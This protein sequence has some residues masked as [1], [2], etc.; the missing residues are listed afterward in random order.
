MSMRVWAAT[1]CAL[2][3]SFVC[4]VAR[5]GT[6]TVWH[7]YRGAEEQALAQVSAR[8]EAAHPATH[9]ELLGIPYEAYA[10]K[11]EAAVPR[12]NGPDLFI[13][14]HQ[15][16]GPYAEE[17][18]ALPAGEAFPEDDVA[19]F[20]AVSV[21]AVTSGGVRWAVPL[22]NKCL[23]LYVND[24]LLRSTPL[25]LEGIAAL[26]D[27]LPK[28]VYPVGYRVTNA[29]DL[30]PMFHALGG[31]LLDDHDRFAF[32][33][34]AAVRTLELARGLIAEG[35][36]PEEPSGALVRQLFISG[37][38]ATVIDGPWLAADLGGVV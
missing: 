12:G 2:A 33:S 13:Q 6:V 7:A 18:L 15:W 25:T 4:G 24:A 14:A 19:A 36:V 3:L 27:T 10:A 11:L 20:D 16:I 1:L 34:P 38:A 9:I 23:A 26:R 17:H 35:A 28:G 8:Y 5:A 32:D 30:A 31:R 37:H 22:A 21:R 29:Y